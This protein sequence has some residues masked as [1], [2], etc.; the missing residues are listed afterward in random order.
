MAVEFKDVKVYNRS[1]LTEAFRMMQLSD[2]GVNLQSV[3]VKKNG[4]IIVGDT[5]N[6]VLYEFSPT[7]GSLLHTIPVQT[8]PWFLAVLSNDRIA[9]SDWIHP[10]ESGCGGCC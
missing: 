9:I 10:G 6:D 5:K 7:D 4:N 3:A 8:E 2:S 1:S